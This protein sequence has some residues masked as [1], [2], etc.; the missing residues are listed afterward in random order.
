M[1]I[2]GIIAEYNPFH[3]G[4]AYQIAEARRRSDAD[5]VCVILSPSWVQRGEP[6]VFRRSARVEMALAGGADIV[7][8][9][10]APF[11]TA[12]AP[13][14]AFWGTSVLTGIGCDALSFGCEN[15]D[16][17][18]LQT[19]A[20]ILAEEPEPFGTLLREGLKKGLSYPAAREAAFS[21]YLSGAATSGTKDLSSGS[22]CSG[23]LHRLLSE[24]NN[25]LA[26]EYCAS[27][28]RQ[29]RNTEI[30]PIRRLGAS[31]NETVLPDFS[32][33]V[34]ALSPDGNAP[35]VSAMAIRNRLKE[36]P[37][38]PSEVLRRFVPEEVFS[39]ME[40]ETPLFPEDFS[41]LLQYAIL[42]SDRDSL[43]SISD[44]GEEIAG[45]IHSA[46]PDFRSFHD[47]IDLLKV[48]Q[49]TYTR[50]SR[51]LTHILLG[52]RTAEIMNWKERPDTGYARILGFRREASP[53]LRELKKR[54]SIPIITRPAD[55][56]RTLS[57]AARSLFEKNTACE[58]IYR[59]VLTSKNRAAGIPEA[60]FENEYRIGPVIYDSTGNGILG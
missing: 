22:P 55:C 18:L 14:F 2:T 34:G 3:A 28:A 29:N 46:S 60:R 59:T 11:A 4:H 25:I 21:G 10:P 12:A 36:S 44:V 49:F 48:R 31:Y 9:M 7:L 41:D 39:R 58:H 24:S 56:F 40:R 35:F 57:P 16:A 50:I 42:R 51:A 15:D 19:A 43:L 6:A 23:R 1:K 38:A 5:A 47:W 20:R 17:A 53:V 32:G 54:T 52:I 26:L 37:T 30:I 27:L 33:E 8:E 13:D 45:R